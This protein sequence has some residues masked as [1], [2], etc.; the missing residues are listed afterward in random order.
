[1]K[2]RPITNVVLLTIQ[3]LAG[4]TVIIS[5][6][7]LAFQLIRFGGVIWLDLAIFLVA[8]A[9]SV[10]CAYLRKRISRNPGGHS[11]RANSSDR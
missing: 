11:L 6:F 2:Q 1:M 8:L 7:R 5:A 9:L 4:L 3:C 10:L